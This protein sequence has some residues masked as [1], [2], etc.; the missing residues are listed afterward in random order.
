VPAK[1]KPPG[2]NHSELG[3]GPIM[4]MGMGQ[5]KGTRP[6]S[7]ESQNPVREATGRKKEHRGPRRLKGP[8]HRAVGDHWR[9]VGGG[10]GG[11]GAKE[12]RLAYV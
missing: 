6:S 5:G 8:Y 10:G 9:G 1:K 4:K 12:P 7:V 2:N 3:V 11:G